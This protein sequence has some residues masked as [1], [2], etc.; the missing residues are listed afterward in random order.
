MWHIK[1]VLKASVCS[2][3]ETVYEY[4][5]LEETEFIDGLIRFLNEY[6]LDDCLNACTE[7]I[8]YDT[9]DI[10][11]ICRDKLYS[12]AH[13]RLDEEIIIK[14]CKNAFLRTLNVDKTINVEAFVDNI[15]GSFKNEY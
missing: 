2:F 13:L 9:G 6:D 15:A 8:L 4:D 1:E 5:S 11:N 14:K 12:I 10:E 3:C 7:G